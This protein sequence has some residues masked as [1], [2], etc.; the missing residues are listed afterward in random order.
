VS[1][2]QPS[3]AV[4]R[5]KGV[6]LPVAA[7]DEEGEIRCRSDGTCVREERWLRADPNLLASIEEHWGSIAE[8]EQAMA[9][10]PFLTCRELL[11]M[12]WDLPR[13]VAGRIILG[14]EIATYSYGIVAAVS[15]AMGL[16]PTK[17]RRAMETASALTRAQIAA[18][19]AEVERQIAEIEALNASIGQDSPGS[20]SEQDSASASSGS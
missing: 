14:E 6:R 3:A 10:K 16:D 4:L 1:D 11:A 19:E 5:N 9:A 15:M 2:R 18:L 13:E 7:L 8:F 12:A 17:A 20:G